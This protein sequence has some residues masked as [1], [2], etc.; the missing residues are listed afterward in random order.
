MLQ[1]KDLISWFKQI[2]HTMYVDFKKM[3]WWEDQY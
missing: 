1:P 3:I 2:L